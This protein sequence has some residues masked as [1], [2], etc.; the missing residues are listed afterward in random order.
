[1]MSCVSCEVVFESN[2]YEFNLGGIDSYE[3]GS[4]PGRDL[5]K[6]TSIAS[7]GKNAS[8]W[9]RSLSLYCQAVTTL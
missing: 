8:V 6:C 1:M 9:L 5:L 7:C 3:I 2:E 4:H